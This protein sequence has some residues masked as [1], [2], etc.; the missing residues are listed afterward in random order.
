[1]PT[2]VT[3]GGST[4]AACPQPLPSAA[5]NLRSC[6]LSSQH[7]P[8]L[9]YATLALA[10]GLSLLSVTIF[11]YRRSTAVSVAAP[12]HV[13]GSGT[14]QSVATP[15]A[16]PGHATAVPSGDGGVM[17]YTYE[18]VRELQHD[19]TAFTQG[20]EF[21]VY[22]GRDVFW[23]STGNY[24]KSQVREVCSRH[25]WFH[26]HHPLSH[27]HVACA[28]AAAAPP[29]GQPGCLRES[30]GIDLCRKLYRLRFEHS[31]DCVSW[32]WL[33]GCAPW[34]CCTWVHLF[35]YYRSFC[36]QVC[37][38][39]PQLRLEQCFPHVC[40]LDPLPLARKIPILSCL[41]GCAATSVLCFGGATVSSRRKAIAAPMHGQLRRMSTQPLQ[42]HRPAYFGR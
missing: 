7:R 14:S 9:P 23:E 27:H 4:T 35:L 40:S 41:S 33:Q 11:L 5:H 39:M 42:H 10:L 26:T 19:P 21:S 32:T 37:P 1:M 3:A 25:R 34:S 18:I 22:K 30:S 31:M 17:M 12:Q 28:V 13:N 2:T 38:G 15:A 8:V 29:A 24:G 6:R 36:G 20:L 16:H